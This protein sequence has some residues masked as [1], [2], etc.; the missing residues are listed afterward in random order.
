MTSFYSKVCHLHV[1][2]CC[3]HIP[4]CSNASTARTHSVKPH[5]VIAIAIAREFLKAK[6]ILHLIVKIYVHTW[7]NTTS[8]YLLVYWVYSFLNPL[9]R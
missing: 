6:Q 4:Q 2:I 1:T 5:N 8:T 7:T 3:R 9:I